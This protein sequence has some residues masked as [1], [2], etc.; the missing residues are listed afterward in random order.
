MKATKKVLV[1]DD[2]PVV[3]SSFDRVLAGKGYAVIHAS[4]GEEA[5]ERL[6]RDDY[7]VVYT[8]IKMPGMSGLE[9]ARRIKAS[10]PWLP[11]VIV[12]GYGSEANEKE[13]KELGATAFLR[14][15]LSPEM[16]EGSMDQALVQ[17]E[18]QA[19]AAIAPPVAQE[20]P[21]KMGVGRFLR[22]VGLFIVSPFVGL[23]YVIALPFVG[24]GLLAWTGYKAL[25]GKQ[26]TH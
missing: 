9:V 6:A 26:E 24:I 23:A 12:T 1:V 7:D 4:D 14:K 19:E 13:A 3:G 2:D 17:P 18:P 15:P 20:Q 10:R 5:L 22:N 21:Q 25:T 16:I 11:V 8:D